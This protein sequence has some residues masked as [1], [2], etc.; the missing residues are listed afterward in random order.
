VLAALGQ[1]AESRGGPFQ[2]V[3]DEAQRDDIDRQQ[4]ACPRRHV[5]ASFASSHE[6]F[7]SV[8][9]ELK[10]DVPSDCVMLADV[11]GMHAVRRRGGVAAL[12]RVCVIPA[13]WRPR[14]SARRWATAAASSP[15]LQA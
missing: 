5:V 10:W 1:I 12:R 15:S 14:C 11:L 4:K 3:L 9:R 2:A 13:P 6:A 8:Y 7:D